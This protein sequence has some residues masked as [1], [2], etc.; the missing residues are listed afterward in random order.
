MLPKNPCQTCGACCAHFRVSFYWSE[1][2]PQLGGTVPVEMTQKLDNFRSCMKGTDQPNPRCMALSG[3]IGQDVNCTIYENRPTPCRE[4]GVDWVDG[5]LM[6]IP[7]DL[8]RCTNARARFGLPPL[9][10]DPHT[11]L[12]PNEPDMP[13]KRAS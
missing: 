1:T 5:V 2:D 6:F 7:A 3:T 9:L 11:P 13:D 10:E 4:F 8:E 12:F